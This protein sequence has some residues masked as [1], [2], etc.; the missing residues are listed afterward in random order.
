MYD[1]SSTKYGLHF[2][3]TF[4]IYISFDCKEVNLILGNFLLHSSVTFFNE[5]G[6]TSEAWNTLLLREGAE[7]AG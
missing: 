3:C 6:R 2:F 5:H 7:P 1:V 4:I